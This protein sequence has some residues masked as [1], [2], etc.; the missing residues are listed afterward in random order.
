MNNCNSKLA[1]IALFA[2][3][4]LDTLMQTVD[5]LLHNELAKESDLFI[6]SDGAKNEQ[7]RD[8]VNTVREYIKTISGF[9]NIKII[10]KEHNCGL[11]DSIIA[12]VTQLTQKFGKVIV[13]E[14]DLLTSPFFLQF[15][16]DGLDMY[17]D[18]DRVIS[19][20]GYI[21]PVAKEL[22]ETFF[23]RGADCWGWAT[24]ERGWKL[25]NPDAKA[26]LDH[27]TREKLLKRFDMDGTY[28]YSKMLK[29]NILKKNNSWAIRWYASA[30]L[31]NKLTLY[32]GQ[33]L[34][35]NIGHGKN[36]THCTVDSKAF[37]V[38][39]LKCRLK[40]EQIQVEE[41]VTARKEIIKY[42]RRLPLQLALA[43]LR[44][45]IRRPFSKNT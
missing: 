14:D 26:L 11:A 44:A 13:V 27:L 6:F 32:P 28:H 4:R 39:L 17:Q 8:A 34:V 45:L 37:N 12:G 31:E 22:P 43:W 29:N 38:N 41:N 25:F 16:N 42:F 36:A 24:W 40:V 3:N 1:P 33:S 21:Y 19:I 10:E 35:E 7:S 20:H 9:K 2:Y 18:D 30:F 15:M 5:A 23:I